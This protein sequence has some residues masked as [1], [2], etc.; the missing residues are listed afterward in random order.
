MFP[1]PTSPSAPSMG[2][3]IVHTKQSLYVNSGNDIFYNKH[4][5]IKCPKTMKGWVSV[6]SH[7]AKSILWTAEKKK[8]HYLFKKWYAH[9]IILQVHGAW[10]TVMCKYLVFAVKMPLWV[11]PCSKEAL[12]SISAVIWH[13]A[14]ET[15]PEV[16]SWVPNVTSQLLTCICWV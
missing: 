15:V 16:V 5:Y 10:L 9:S 6:F 13:P 7:P 2:V 12:M 8:A 14:A 11:S 3:P 4:F 1:F